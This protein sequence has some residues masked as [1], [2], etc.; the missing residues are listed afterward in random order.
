MSD[1]T[2]LAIDTDAELQKI[3]QR[4][5]TLPD[6]IASPAILKNA[7]NSTARKVRAQ[8]KKDTKARY[9][10]SDGKMLTDKSQGAPEVLTASVTTLAAT[11]RS[12]GPMQDIMAFMT[13]PNTRSAAAAA[14]V[15]NS[16]SMKLLEVN[17][18]KAFVTTF[19][20]GHT[21]I[22]QRKGASRLPVKKLLSP[23]VPHMMGND[24]VREKAEGL[25]YETLQSEIE[26]RIEKVLASKA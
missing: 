23:A 1:Q 7:I 21:A 18:L 12:R 3:I 24:E 10:I 2:I 13:Q 15:L 22:V 11:V 4:L 17:G 5:N 25:A 20:S 14:K 16:G 8:L 19:A 9:A 26:K 6:Q